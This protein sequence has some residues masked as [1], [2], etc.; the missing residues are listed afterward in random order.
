MFQ[1]W[2]NGKIQTY[3]LV[4]KY[5]GGAVQP[6]APLSP[7]EKAKRLQD[8]ASPTPASQSQ[9][10]TQTKT[11]KQRLI[12]I[13]RETLD[14]N[15]HK[16][17]HKKA[18]LVKEIMTSPV[19]TLV[20]ENSIREAYDLILRKGFRHIP[21]TDAAGRLTG[22]ISDRDILKISKEDLD[23]KPR[24]HVSDFMQSR[25]LTV[26]PD[27]SIVDAAAVLLNENF[28][29]LPVTN[30]EAEVLGIITTTDILHAIVLQAPIN[31]WA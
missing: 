22:I 26:T 9:S 5:R 15:R 25:V 7:T 11:K 31:L 14:P 1:F 18:M 23:A 28:S 27:A 30:A 12:E 16:E 10:D 13:Y 17:Q 19:N 3:S 8:R 20:Q 24:K 4:N 29:S 21:I 6:I 2:S